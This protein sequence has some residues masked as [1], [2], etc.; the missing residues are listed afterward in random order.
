M[1]FPALVAL[2]VASI[3]VAGCFGPE[4]NPNAA[5]YANED[6]GV[7]AV[8]PETSG[9]IAYDP[10]G[11]ATPFSDMNAGGAAIA[12]SATPPLTLTPAGQAPAPAGTMPRR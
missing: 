5:P 11:K 6:G 3:A 7:I 10:Y 4:G 1:K 9:M 12:P 8:K 2:T